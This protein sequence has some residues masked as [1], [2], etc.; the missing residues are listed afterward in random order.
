V[1]ESPRLAVNNDVAS[2]VSRA[3][4][5]EDFFPEFEAEHLQK[6]FPRSG[7]YRYAPETTIIK[8]GEP[9]RDLF[10]VYAGSVRIQ[11]SFGT[12]AASLD[13][14]GPGALIG[15]IALLRDGLRTASVV[16]SEDAQ[17]FRL[18]FEDLQYILK[19]NAALGDHLRGLAEKRLK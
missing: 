11:Q 12:A 16:A 1:E 19:N 18:V 8:Q 10:V 5:L 4:K 14:L 9:G 13:T 7:L 6:L 15:E 3:L 2:A 17:V